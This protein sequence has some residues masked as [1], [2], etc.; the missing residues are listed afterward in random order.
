MQD[1]KPVVDLGGEKFLP[2]M[3]FF[4][5]GLNGVPPLP[6]NWALEE[7]DGEFF[8]RKSG[9]DVLIP[10]HEF[11]SKKKGGKWFEVNHPNELMGTYF[12]NGK[13]NAF[14]CPTP[15]IQ[16]EA[17]AEYVAKREQRASA[18][19]SERRNPVGKDRSFFRQPETSGYW[20]CHEDGADFEAEYLGDD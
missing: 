8:C 18:S 13:E 4:M 9:S 15:E 10:L 20:W 7:E 16:A 2:P 5:P 1:E 12:T 19:F 17:H 3:P 14:K 11:V 6:N